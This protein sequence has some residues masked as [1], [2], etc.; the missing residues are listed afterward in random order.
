MSASTCRAA[1]SVD[2]AAHVHGRAAHGPHKPA[3]AHE[4]V[5]RN[6]INVFA[7]PEGPPVLRGPR[8]LSPLDRGKRETERR[9]GKRKRSFAALC[10][11]DRSKATQAHVFWTGTMLGPCAARRRSD[12][13]RGQIAPA[14]HAA[15]STARAAHGSQLCDA[16]CHE[17]APGGTKKYFPKRGHKPRGAF[18]CAPAN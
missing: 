5:T 14:L 4:M 2:G 7:A 1:F 17:P 16:S 10:G 18:P 8:S 11:P 9:E 13:P 6:G 3:S 15:M 12:L